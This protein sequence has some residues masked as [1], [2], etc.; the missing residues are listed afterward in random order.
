MAG[1]ALHH[2]R[3]S[4]SRAS[5]AAAP[6]AL[7]AAQA[8]LRDRLPQRP[9]ASVARVGAPALLGR[10]VSGARS[11]WR[12]RL[13]RGR[14]PRVRSLRRRRHRVEPARANSADGLRLRR[15]RR[16][17]IRRRPQSRHGLHLRDADRALA[18]GAAAASRGGAA[19]ARMAA[20]DSGARR[21]AREARAEEPRDR[22]RR[23]HHRSE[24]L[25]ARQPSGAGPRDQAVR[26]RAFRRAFA[27][28]T[29]RVHSAARSHRPSCG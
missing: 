22:A 4:R 8:P 15:R 20:H 19:A 13:G 24:P 12:R 11:A 9:Y 17:H 27:R 26:A 2:H 10:W 6:G 18:D 3:L 1:L 14:L 7:A 28:R 25:R 29:S 21:L 23:H 16:G 5:M